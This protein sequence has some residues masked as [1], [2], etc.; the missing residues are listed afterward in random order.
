MRA[1]IKDIAYHLPERIVTNEALQEENPSWDM[2]ILEMST[3]VQQRHIARDDETALDLGLEACH[4]LFQQSEEMYSKIDGILF[5]T[6]TPDH[7]TPNNACI[8]HGRLNLGEAV[9][10]LHSNPGCSGYIYGLA[11][12]QGLMQSGMVENVLLVTADTLSKS[13]H[14]QDRSTRVLFGDGAAA[15]WITES[16]STQGI[17]DIECC[18][19]G[20]HDKIIVPAG[21]YRMPKSA[22]PAIPTTDHN[23][24]VRTLENAHI[25]MM[26]I[27]GFV[28][29]K[30]PSHIRKILE[31]NQLTLDDIDAFVWHQGGKVLLDSLSRRLRV[32]PEKV[33]QNLR[34]MGNTSSSSIPIA[35]KDAMDCGKISCGD[36]V[37]LC[38]FGVGLSW[39]SAIIEV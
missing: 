12:A 37:L 10:A 5:C 2:D 4:K 1:T 32:D 39:G 25:D 6:Q 9:F 15:S 17:I 11:L 7:Y 24:N 22:E 16:D 36:K 14:K 13:V 28:N 8:L 38:G 30:L 26:G 20:D 18:T 31:R 27:L 23:G 33:I 29:S 34:E 21:G 35:M 3:G 19:F